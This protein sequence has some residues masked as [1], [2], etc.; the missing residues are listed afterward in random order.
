MSL[1]ICDS[2]SSFDKQ[3]TAMKKALTKL[4]K[5]TKSKVVST[6]VKEKEARSDNEL[7]GR[8]RLVRNV[9]NESL[10]MVNEGDME[11]DEAMKELATLVVK[12]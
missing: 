2:E 10:E 11:F 7:Q 1:D 9:M 8:I 12:I 4:N 5:E 3:Q 6:M